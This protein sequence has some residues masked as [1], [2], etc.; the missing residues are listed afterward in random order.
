MKLSVIVPGIRPG[1]WKRLYESIAAAMNIPSNADPA[2]MAM[3]FEMI[4]VS[5]YDL[6]RSLEGRDNIKLI[7]DWGSPIR[8]QQ[9]GLLACSGDYVSWAADDGFY[10]PG[11]LDLAFKSVEGKD[12]KAL[13]VGKYYEGAVN[14]DGKNPFMD[15]RKYYLIN[16]H[17]GS[18]S[19]YIANDCLMIMVGIISRQVLL[20]VG[21]W[22]CQFEVCPMSYNDLSVRLYNFG[23]EFIFQQEIMFRCSHMPGHQ[24][25]HGPIH[26]AQT[27][28]DEPLF[29]KIYATADSLE[30]VKIDL[31]NH[32]LVQARW[33]RRFG[34]EKT[35]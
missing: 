11:S 27:L 10:F 15:S 12:Y 23:C 30:R 14:A 16:T 21:G 18:R 6:P 29:R 25:D 7:K 3:A 17:D 33:E 34:A 22:D 19:P 26:D 9:I 4:V 20:E 24:G 31:N 35:S 28:H 5:P 2:L 32:L 13:V 1:N 8:A